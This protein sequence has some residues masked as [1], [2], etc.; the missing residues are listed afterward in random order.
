MPC[1]EEGDG[2]MGLTEKVLSN[3]EDS[4]GAR[5][6]NNMLLMQEDFLDVLL[7]VEG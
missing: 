3:I 7:K 1:G 4:A 2:P 5:Q 6:D